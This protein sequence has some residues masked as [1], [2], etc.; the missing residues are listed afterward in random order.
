MPLR[1]HRRARLDPR[2]EA[3]RRLRR[4]RRRRGSSAGSATPGFEILEVPVADA[5]GLGVNAISLGDDRVISSRALEGPQRAA[6]RARPRG[7]R[8]R[9]RD[10]HARRR[11]RPLPRARRCAG[12]AWVEPRSAPAIDADGVIADLRELDALTGGRGRRAAALLG[13]GVAGGA[14][15]AAREARPRSGS[16]PS[17]TRRGTSGRRFPGADR[18]APALAVGS[19]LDSVPA[20]GW[21]D[22]ALGVMAAL[23]VAPRLVGVRRRCRR[24]TSS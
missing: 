19:H 16:S 22:G 14:R 21:L 17:S 13:G 15:A 12:S 10:V 11:R 6:P 24:A 1:P 2:A 8:P 5:F 18:E 9:P 20:G 23:G 7:L 3:R 4:R